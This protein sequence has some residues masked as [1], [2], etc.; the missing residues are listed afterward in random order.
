MDELD[1]LDEEEFAVELLTVAEL[2]AAMLDDI[3]LLDFEIATEL[4]DLD[5]ATLV[6][7]TDTLELLDGVQLVLPGNPSGDS[8]VRLM[9]KL[10]AGTFKVMPSENNTYCALQPKL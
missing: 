10:F 2:L 4:L 6:C 9:R 5:E 3:E 7:E 1:K 8:P